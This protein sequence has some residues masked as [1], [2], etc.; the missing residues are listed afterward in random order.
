MIKVIIV[1]DEVILREGIKL[2][3]EK[4]REIKVIGTA[5]DGNEAYNICRRLLPDVLLMDIK[6]PKV[7]GITATK[8]IK[9]EFPNTK[10]LVLTMHNDDESI[11]SSLE[12]G[13]D[14]Y[15]LKYMKP[16][17]LILSIKSCCAGLKIIHQNAMPNIVKKASNNK[18]NFISDGTK[19][20]NLTKREKELLRH[21]LKGR[22][23]EE[24]AQNMFISQGSVRN[25]ISRVLKKLNLNNKMQLAIF[26]IKNDIV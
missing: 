3:I 8:R 16:E 11:L 17:E 12:N 15:V 5:G 20:I 7:D 26:A 18:I 10:I 24:I 1:D 21:I 23:N 22:D 14:G 13:A 4:D 25:M 6:M 19:N 9:A 2:I